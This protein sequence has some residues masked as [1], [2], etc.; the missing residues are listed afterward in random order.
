MENNKY[1]K[2]FLKYA[3]L[4][5]LLFVSFSFVFTGCGKDDDNDYEAPSADARVYGNGGLAVRKG[6]YLYFVNGYRTY[7]DVTKEEKT[8]SNADNVVRGAIYRTKLSAT[9]DL[10]VDE[11]GKIVAD[12][13]ER[14]IDKIACFENGG[15]YIVGNYI[16]YA[17]P[18]TQDDRSGNLLNKYVDYCRASLSNPS[19]R[20]VLY[21]SDGEVTDGEWHV[22][23][24]NGN[25]YLVVKSAKKVVCIKNS[26]DAYDMITDFTAVK[27]WKNEDGHALAD[28]EKYVYY[29]RAVGD[30]DSVTSGNVVARVKLGSSTEEVIKRD[31]TTNT[32]KDLKNGKIYYTDSDNKLRVATPTFGVVAGIGDK[33]LT[34]K[35][36]EEMYVVENNEAS[37]TLNRILVVESSDSSKVLSYYDNGS[38]E[39]TTVATANMKILEV[40]GNYVYYYDSDNA[41]IYRVDIVSKE[42]TKLTNGSNNFNFDVE[43]KMNFDVDVN[44]MYFLNGYTVES[45]TQ[46]YLERVDL[47]HATPSHTFVGQFVDGEAPVEEDED[48]ENDDTNN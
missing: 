45:T 29:T 6:E 15:L 46:Y 5:L 22:Y 48:T 17:T 44:Y 37:S 24:D 31:G 40:E 38:W 18:N 27:F 34:Q 32:L 20:E 16:Y 2:K 3:T 21:T 19:D 10:T 11:N 41:A 26:D 12:S 4:I 43:K 35:S 42:I 1:M 7:T 23:G 14:V 33:A 47:T 8:L 28:H 30:N 9:G 25:I 39:K 36:Y 13:V